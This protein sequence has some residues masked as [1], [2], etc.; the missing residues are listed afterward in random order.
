MPRAR[1]AFVAALLGTGISAIVQVGC[2]LSDEYSNGYGSDAAADVLPPDDASTD[3]PAF[4]DSSALT[5]VTIITD[6]GPHDVAVDAFDA[7]AD[8]DAGPGPWGDYCYG[9]PYFVTP[10]SGVTVGLTFQVQ[11]QAPA[12]IK[13]ML[14]YLNGNS[15]PV[16]PDIDGSSYSGTLTVKDPGQYVIN[17]NAWNHTNDAH[18]SDHVTFTVSN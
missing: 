12:C 4:P 17:A 7:G 18:A 1:A 3:A 9:L 2:T 15:T 16:T 13:D 11:L 10:E 5:D 8:A 14:V 6:S